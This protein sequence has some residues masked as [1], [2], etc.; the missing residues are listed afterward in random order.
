[1]YGASQELSIAY[2]SNFGGTF[3][4]F[5]RMSRLLVHNKQVL[6]RILNNT[7]T[8]YTEKHCE[9]MEVMHFRF[10]ETSFPILLLVERYAINSLCVYLSRDLSKIHAGTVLKEKSGA[11]FS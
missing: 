9:Y 4:K 11:L 3:K 5:A 2:L 7:R 1:M 6:W 8:M 10:L